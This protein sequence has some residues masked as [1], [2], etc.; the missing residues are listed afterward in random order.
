MVVKE[1]TS[2]DSSKTESSEKSV[3]SRASIDGLAS[4]SSM[5]SEVES[6]GEVEALGFRAPVGGGVNQNF[7][8]RK[9]VNFDIQNELITKG[10]DFEFFEF[11]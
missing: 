6:E 10:H 11:I 1:S 2:E 9:S 7:D 3:V 5:G 4:S 8:L